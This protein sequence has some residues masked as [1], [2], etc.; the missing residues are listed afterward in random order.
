MAVLLYRPAGRP[1]GREIARGLGLSHGSCAFFTRAGRIPHEVSV[2]WGG[3]ELPQAD[4]GRTLNPS[5]AIRAA[6]GKF[7]AFQRFRNADVPIPRFTASIGEA[8]TWQ[9]DG[10]TVLGRTTEGFQ[11]RGITVY[12]PV[13]TLG[14]HPLYVE[15][16]PNEREYRIHVVGGSVVSVQRK[17]LEYPERRHSDHIKNVPNGYVF[18]TPRRGLHGSRHTAAIEAVR[19]LGLDFGAVDLIVDNEGR[20]YV[21]EVNTAPACSPKRVQAYVE[22]LRPLLEARA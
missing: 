19:S 4:T 14:Q 20:E 5:E 1:T 6:S 7:G 21:L 11:G 13:D 10:S 2:R 22:A 15:F 18:K 3:T 16:I 8:R 12:Q 9:D 17:Y